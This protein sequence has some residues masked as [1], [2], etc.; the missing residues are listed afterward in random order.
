MFYSTELITPLGT[1]TLAS[2]GDALCGLWFHGQKYFAA[3]ISGA[4]HQKDGLEI[5]RET[6]NWLERYFTGKRPEIRE[7]PLRPIGS[8]FR[9]NVWKIL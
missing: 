9:Q 4:M 2:D 7:L 3:S 5:F 8:E 1:V 6:K